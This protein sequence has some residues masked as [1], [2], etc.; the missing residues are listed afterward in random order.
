[1]PRLLRLHF[2]SIGHEHARLAPLTLDFRHDQ[3][4]GA[5]SVVW[6]RN[7]GGKSSIL[8]LFY[9]VFPVGTEKIKP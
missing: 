9:S 8:N 4:T 2:A 3:G 1:M 6:L 5:D 7:A